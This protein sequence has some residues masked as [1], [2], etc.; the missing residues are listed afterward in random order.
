MQ[1]AGG[2]KG[3]LSPGQFGDGDRGSVTMLAHLW[4]TP[5]TPTHRSHLQ[6]LPSAMLMSKAAGRSWTRHQQHSLPAGK[7]TGVLIQVPLKGQEEGEAPFSKLR[8][9]FQVVGGGKLGGQTEK[10]LPGLRGY[11]EKKT[12]P[13]FLSWKKLHL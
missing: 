12:S 11:G 10:F 13:A 1:G 2:S 5:S 4:G 7:A 3:L 6:Q 9:G 8:F